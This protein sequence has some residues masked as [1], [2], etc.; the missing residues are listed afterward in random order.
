VARQLQ[1]NQ[2]S[3]LPESM[4]NLTLLTTL[5]VLARVARDGQARKRNVLKRLLPLRYGVQAPGQQPIR[6]AHP[7][8]P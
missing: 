6:R 2:L 7:F 8:L 3:A 1:F 4:G 5:C